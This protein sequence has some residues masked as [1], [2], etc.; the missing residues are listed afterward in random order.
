[1]NNEQKIP[2]NDRIERAKQELERLTSEREHLIES[3]K[4]YLYGIKDE[5]CKKLIKMR[6]ISLFY[7]EKPLYNMDILGTRICDDDISNGIHF[8]YIDSN[9]QIV[10]S[11]IE[12]IRN[13]FGYLTSGYLRKF[14]IHSTSTNSKLDISYSD[15]VSNHIV[16]MS[17]EELFDL[18][19]IYQPNNWFKVYV[20]ELYDKTVI[21]HRRS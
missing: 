14:W 18:L 11:D 3:I 8:D 5:Y 19:T 2:I 4:Y 16:C 6:A 1:M 21:I 9:N 10:M 12:D 13:I 7:H 20:P 15:F 17:D